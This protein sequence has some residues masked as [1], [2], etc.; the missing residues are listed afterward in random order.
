MR[1][2]GPS[3]VIAT[4]CSKFADLVRALVDHGLDRDHHARQQ[5]YTPT[6]CT[7]VGYGWILVHLG[8]DAV[9]GVFP[10]HAVAP[11]LA[12]AL[13]RMADVAESAARDSPRNA[14]IQALARRVDQP[15]RLGGNV[16][17]GESGGVVADIA[18]DGGA[19]V[20][21]DDVALPKDPLL[22][23]DAVDHL[24]VYGNACGS[25]KS[26]VAEESRCCTV[27]ENVLVRDPVD[28]PCGDARFHRFSR[29]L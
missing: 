10:N 1:I 5:A 9:S 18:M 20:N 6:G 4:V 23:G 28:L 24:V 29:Y 19:K 14:L 2:F 16:A 21:A 8:S 13:H 27:L 17:D 25:G 12:I 15:L 26:A 3:A 11:C 7:V 22:A